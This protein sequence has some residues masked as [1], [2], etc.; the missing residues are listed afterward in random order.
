MD[1]EIIDVYTEDN[2]P[3]GY[4]AEPLTR[5]PSYAR[6]NEDASRNGLHPREGA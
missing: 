6:R 5:T 2:E 3:F 4:I 1:D